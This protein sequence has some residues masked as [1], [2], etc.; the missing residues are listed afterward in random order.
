MT[1]RKSCH[2]FLIS[3]IQH[4]V[5][6]YHRLPLSSRDVQD[7]FQKRGIEV[8]H[9]TLRKW[10]LKFSPLITEELRHREPRRGVYDRRRCPLLAVE[11]CR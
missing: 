3:I 1:D 4:A 5:W 10:N 11:G 7:L 9:D 2:R 8:S 6:L